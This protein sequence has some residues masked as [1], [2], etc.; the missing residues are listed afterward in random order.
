MGGKRTF[1]SYTE[2]MTY[3]ATKNRLG[4]RLAVAQ[5]VGTACGLFLIGLLSPD[6]APF[7]ARWWA[8]L[9]LLLFGGLLI[10]L[11]AFTIAV[12]VLHACTASILKRT[13]VWCVAVPGGLLA[14]S[15]LMP[16]P[17][18]SIHWLTGIALCAVI[19]GMI[20]L[21]W[22]RLRPMTLPVD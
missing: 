6:P 5:L 17:P 16:S 13:F 12:L 14:L 8:E 7:T 18:Q 11:P 9:Q 1:A 15:L 21:A 2:V 19:A 3:A 10:G 20:F 22:Q 4:G